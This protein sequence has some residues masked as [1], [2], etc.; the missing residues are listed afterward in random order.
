MGMVEERRRDRSGQPDLETHGL[1]GGDR[2]ITPRATRGSTP[3]A[4]PSWLR[5]F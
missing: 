4:Y 1:V 3:N 2:P 5:L